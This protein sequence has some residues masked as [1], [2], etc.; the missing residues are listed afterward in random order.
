M[1]DARTVFI[2]ALAP[3]GAGPRTL[4]RQLD[5]END[6]S[7]RAALILALGEHTPEQLSQEL[8]AALMPKLLGWYRTDPD[9]G[10]HGAIDWL[11]RHRKE[12]LVDRPF[13]WGGRQHLEQIDTELA[14]KPGPAGQRWYVNGQGQ[15]FTA[16]RGPVEFLMGTPADEP[17]RPE[18][19]IL[20][21]RTIGR[22]FAVAAKPVT[23]AE[24][25][26]FLEAMTKA[27][28]QVGHSYQKK[29][30]PEP[31][32]PIIDVTWYE[33]A[34]YCRWLSEAEQ[35]APVQMVYPPIEEILKCADGKMPLTLP[36]RH[37]ART[38]Y[39]LPTES[40]LEY[41]CRAAT[42]TRWHF[43]GTDTFLPRYAWFVKNSDDRTWPV[44]QK[45]PNELGLFD[46]HGN[47]WNWCHDG[48]RPYDK[49][50]MADSE[51]DRAVQDSVLRVLRGGSFGVPGVIARCAYRMRLDA[52]N[53]NIIV[54]FRLARTLPPAH[55]AV[56]PKESGR[57]HVRRTRSQEPIGNCG[58]P[59]S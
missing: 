8:G 31:G 25:E 39:R 11:L 53:R 46:V 2:H 47:A 9:P 28:R 23:V 52:T 57:F 42:A 29:Y 56:V 51:D 21:R 1:P 33:A 26:K 34:M 36:A 27:R 18:D 5:K 37:L 59:R 30:A 7:I 15:T 43:G 49:A 24:W 44:G 12:G 45:K 14:G 6:A 13:A 4:V 55:F 20:H 3:W 17:V 32:C 38:G 22:S 10:V 54:G 35:M 50:G 48:Y 16:V 40:E 19:E 41:A 58:W